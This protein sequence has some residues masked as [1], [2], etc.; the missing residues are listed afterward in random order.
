VA[1]KTVQPDLG[2][3]S[4]TCPH[5]GAIAHQT[6]FNLFLQRCDKDK[7]PRTV[8][9]D[10]LEVLAQNRDIDQKMKATLKNYFTKRLS[11]LPFDDKQEHT[12]YL[13]YQL[14]NVWASRCY[15][16]EE[17][18]AWIGERLI[19]PAEPYEVAPNPEMP[20]DVKLDFLEASKI[21]DLSARGAAALLRLCIQKLVKHLGQRG[22]NLNDDIG[23]LVEQKKITQGIQQALDVVRVVGNHAVHPGTIDFNDNKAVASK[24][25][26]LV[27]VIV[28]AT[29][30]T[31]KHIEQ[32]YQSV[33]PDD[34][35]KAI[36]KRDSPI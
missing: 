29:I 27:N 1:D 31:P 25:F 9:D 32:I 22:D 4:F 12:A 18:A 5:C 8:R 14:E 36:Q 20:H 33:V 11:G 10:A 28:E 19:Y 35:R 15:S 24:L 34:T 13:D 30:S 7:P 23:S 17:Y 16:C 3:S 6:W 2:E 26:G 21:V